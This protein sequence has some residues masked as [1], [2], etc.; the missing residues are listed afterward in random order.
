MKTTTLFV[1]AALFVL[2]VVSYASESKELDLR[3]ALFSDNSQ[4]RECK[5]LFGS[6]MKDGDCCEHLECTKKDGWC[7]WDGTFRRMD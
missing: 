3:D 5:Y 6:C 2:S 7:R 4:E 1:I